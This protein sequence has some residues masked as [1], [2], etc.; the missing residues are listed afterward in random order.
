MWFT[1]VLWFGYEIRVEFKFGYRS[2]GVNREE[3]EIRVANWLFNE[4]YQ[5]SSIVSLVIILSFLYDSISG[6]TGSVICKTW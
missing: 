2:N 4:I 1:D 5:S 3:A 6:S